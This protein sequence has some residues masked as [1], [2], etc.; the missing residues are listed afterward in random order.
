MSKFKNRLEKEREELKSRVFSR[1][2][3]LEMLEEYVNDADF[4]SHTIQTK[5]GLA[6]KV[7]TMPAKEFRAFLV[8]IIVDFGVERADAENMM[9]EYKFKAK[10]LGPV[11]DFFNDFL[12]NY[13]TIGR[14]VN[15]F[16][17][18]EMSGS[19]ILEDIEE[20]VKEVKDPR[21][22]N[23]EKPKKFRK[24]K[25]HKKLKAKMGKMDWIKEEGP[26]E[27]N[28]VKIMELAVKK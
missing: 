6:E 22:T 15:L 17:M 27:D 1:T 11:I 20:G 8:D 28:L 7:E 13:L 16:N 26:D 25:A 9:A 18:E 24:T 21:D 5:A 12:A 14:K 3:L 10:N 19:L 2:N 4:V 23:N